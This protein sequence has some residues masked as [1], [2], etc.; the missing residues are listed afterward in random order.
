M[1]S[2]IEL[3]IIGPAPV[4]ALRLEFNWQHLEQWAPSA[5]MGEHTLS[6]DQPG[7]RLLS[8]MF[9]PM[10]QVEIRLANAY[11]ISHGHRPAAR[12]SPTHR[13]TQLSPTQSASCMCVW[14][15]MHILKCVV[16]HCACSPPQPSSEVMAV[17][18]M[19]VDIECSRS[20]TSYAFHDAHFM[21]LHRLP[22]QW[23]LQ[24]IRP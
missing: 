15:I 17:P 14:Q 12:A 9:L 11:A 23:H 10:T 7:F 20:D 19:L 16:L 6:W 5:V 2:C 22:N 8:T 3:S 4:G 21:C 18:E 1:L 13:T 24:M